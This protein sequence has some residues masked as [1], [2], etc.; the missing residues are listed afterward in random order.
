MAAVPY[1]C[2]KKYQCHDFQGKLPGTTTGPN[3]GHTIVLQRQV[4]HWLR[5]TTMLY[6]CQQRQ[7]DELSCRHGSVHS[8]R[9]GH[10]SLRY[11]VRAMPGFASTMA[12]Q[13]QAL[14][15]IVYGLSHNFARCLSPVKS[16][17]VASAQ[18]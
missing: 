9:H 12:C 14:P 15:I 6:C 18:P 2:A 17:A 13:Q 7:G 8:H 11:E 16:L 5:T 3:M 10:R 1:P 4:L